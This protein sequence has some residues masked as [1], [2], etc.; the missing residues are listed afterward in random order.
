MVAKRFTDTD[1]WDDEWFQNLPALMKLLACYL[2]DHL[3]HAGI[4][5]QNK[6]LAEFKLK[7]QFDWDSVPS[8]FEKRIFFRGDYWF[9][10]KFMTKQYGDDLN[11]GDAVRSAVARI[12]ILGFSTIAKDVIGSP[13]RRVLGESIESPMTPKAKAKAM[14]TAKKGSMRGNKFTPPTP[15]MVEEYATS[16]GADNFDGNKFC[17]FYESKGWK[18]GNTPMKD[19]KAA[20]RTWLSKAGEVHGKPDWQ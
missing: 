3:D 1:R 18:V 17:D 7:A 8:T 10:P 15:E 13:Y 12:E 9:I 20:V 16:K 14:A 11:R 6:A 5:K 2:W 19:W 4:W